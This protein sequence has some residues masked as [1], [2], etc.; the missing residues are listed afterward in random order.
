MSRRKNK[1]TTPKRDW[2]S[3]DARMISDDVDWLHALAAAG[4]RDEAWQAVLGLTALPHI[5]RV[6]HESHLHLSR[7]HPASAN[8]VRLRFGAEIAAAR[9]TVKL[10]DDTGKLYDGVV[11][12]FTRIAEAHRATLG[13]FN[14]LAVMSR[15]GRLFTTSRVSDYNGALGDTP[16]RGQAGPHSHAYRLGLDMGESLPLILLHL[17]VLIP[18][19]PVDVPLPD[20]EA[21]TERS[22]Q[23]ATFYRHSYEP[24][25]PEALKD[26]LCVIE[27]TVNTS[28]FIFSAYTQYFPGP[29]F[30]ARLISTVHALRAL[31]EIVERFPALAARPGMTAVQTLL[32]TPAAQYLISDAIR[33]LRNRCMHYGVPSHLTIQDTKS[34]DY[35]LVQATTDVTYESVVGNI[36]GTL[37]RLSEVLLDWRA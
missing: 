29:V 15:D 6:V 12:D 27:S 30:R 37:N 33:P 34:P 31:A 22:M 5:A 21:P 28:L 7:K 16:Q 1:K 9:H 35:G 19:E 25:F 17:G 4:T 18:M 2:S 36:D 10:L 23:A 13:R 26:V 14:D 8:S 3:L 24:E 20:G 11:A 32:N